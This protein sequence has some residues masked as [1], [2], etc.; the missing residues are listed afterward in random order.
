MASNNIVAAFRTS[1]AG[2]QPNTTAGSVASNAQYIM[3]GQF[4]LN[5]PDKILYTSDGTNLIY[6]GA[7]QVNMNVTNSLSV[8]SILSV[9]TT[10]IYVNTEIYLNGSNG[11]PGQVLT[12][13]G[14]SNVYW[15]T[16]GGGSVN[17]NATWFFNNTFSIGNSTA[18][19]TVSNNSVVTSNGYVQAQFISTSVQSGTTYTF[20]NTDSGTLVQSNSAFAAVFT[21]PATLP[22]NSRILVTQLGLG[23]V[24]IANAAGITLGSRTGSYTIGNQYGTVSVYMANSTLAVIDGN[25]ANASVTVVNVNATYAWTNTQSFAANITFGN[26]S[27][28]TFGNS[29]VNTTINATA[30]VQGG[31]IFTANA[32]TGLRTMQLTINS[33][34]NVAVLPTL[35][36]TYAIATGFALT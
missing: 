33:V 1:V 9:N 3:A 29:T 7:N 13:N 28:V 14:T 36:V 16:V 10:A 2:R 26:T 22:A 18:N 15:S 19:T 27:T 20:A 8:G 11:Q 31:A 24:T 4:A 30:M 21:I 5:M 34:S 12:S 35:G 23:S 32:A 25:L 6:V 17:T